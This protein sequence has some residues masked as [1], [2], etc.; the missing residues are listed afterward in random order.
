MSYTYDPHAITGDTVSRARFELGDIDVKGG[1]H[2]AFLSDEEIQAI[3]IAYPGRWRTALYHLAD[4][5]CMRLSFETDWRDDGTAFSLNQRAERWW[6]LRD[7]LKKDAEM[8]ETLPA[9]GFVKDTLRA[10]D[11]GHYFHRDM[12]NSPY[13][14]PPYYPPGSPPD[15]RGRR[16]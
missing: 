12:T 6:K 5:V 14:Q 16:R 1:E 9:S 15:E 11:G 3:I 13:V 2:T 8:E 4:A 7:K 10:S